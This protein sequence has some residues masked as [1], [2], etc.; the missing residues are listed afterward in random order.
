MQQWLLLPAC[1]AI[2]KIV[3]GSNTTSSVY[4]HPLIVAV[5][6]ALLAAMLCGLFNGI[7]VSFLNIQ[8]MVATLVLYTADVQLQDGLPVT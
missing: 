6:V 2:I 3:S 1:G 7:L 4:A 8:P 5:L